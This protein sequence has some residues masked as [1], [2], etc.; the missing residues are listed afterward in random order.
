MDRSRKS[1]VAI[2]SARLNS[3][4]RSLCFRARHDSSWLG[5]HHP[6]ITAGNATSAFPAVIPEYDYSEHRT[7]S[8][9]S[10]HQQFK[11]AT[12]EKPIA[13]V[14]DLPKTP[15]LAS[16]ISQV[17]F[18]YLSVRLTTPVRML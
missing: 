9:V 11:P 10:H 7:M 14:W 13:A 8:A 5:I 18:V 3:I 12:V 17:V 6:G 15:S 16:N 1:S 2:A 4:M